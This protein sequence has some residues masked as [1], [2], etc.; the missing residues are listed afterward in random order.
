MGNF[1]AEAFIG[2]MFLI[3]VFLICAISC[4]VIEFVWICVYW[5]FSPFWCPRRHREPWLVEMCNCL[6]YICYFVAHYYCIMVDYFSIRLKKCKRIEKNKVKPIIYDDVHII[7]INP[8][9]KYQIATVS[10]VVN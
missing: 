10:K 1:F 8:F 9:E 3:A 7:V 2:I 4:K 6:V 5:C